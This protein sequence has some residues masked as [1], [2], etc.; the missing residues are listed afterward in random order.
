MPPMPPLITPFPEAT[1][2][3]H[4]TNVWLVH[5]LLVTLAT[6]D[7]RTDDFGDAEADADDGVE[8]GHGGREDGE[9]GHVVEVGYLRKDHLREAEQE[10]VVAIPAG[11]ARRVVA[12]PVVAV[13]LLNRPASARGNNNLPLV[14]RRLCIVAR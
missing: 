4:R 1:G 9:P 12:F 8:E 13:G 10:H 11:E 2:R 5:E 14:L 7:V 3:D 6:K